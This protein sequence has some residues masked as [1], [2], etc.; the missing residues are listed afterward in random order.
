MVIIV[1]NSRR[2]GGDRCVARQTWVRRRVMG[3]G[4]YPDSLRFRREIVA[5]LGI[6]RSTGAWAL[7]LV[8]NG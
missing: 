8:S 2:D 5:D 6:R 7:S 3:V 4:A 1:T